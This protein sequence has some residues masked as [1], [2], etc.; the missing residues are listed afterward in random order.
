MTLTATRT[1]ASVTVPERGALQTFLERA[2][3][4]LEAGHSTLSI[5]GAEVALQPEIADAVV[6][7]LNRLSEGRGVMVS[8]V[9]ELLT[10]GQAASMLGVSRTYLCKLLDKE[11]LRFEYRGTHRRV[12]TSDLLEYL[13]QQQA[14]RREAL[15]E[16]QRLSHEAGLYDDDF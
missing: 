1:V 6:D 2:R 13:R 14:R 11:K 15:E 9:D 8:S 7:L 3:R 16:V 4:E 10:T 5:G 12:R